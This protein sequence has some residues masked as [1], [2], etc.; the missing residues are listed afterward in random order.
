MDGDVGR[1]HAVLSLDE[2]F[3]S[4]VDYVEYRRIAAKIRREPAFDTVLRLDDFLDDF[5]IGL[6][7]G[8]AKSID[9]LFGVA[10]DEDFARSQFYLA[11][12]LG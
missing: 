4:A 10:D 3:K 11:P 7:V 8:P 9:R 6:D 12:V 5:E 1:L 2:G